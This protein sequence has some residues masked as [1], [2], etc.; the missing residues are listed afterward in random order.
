MQPTEILSDEHQ[1]ILTVIDA[2]E[3]ECKKLIS[4]EEIDEQFFKKAIDFI[5]HYADKF[6]HAKEEDIL[7]K[8][9]CNNAEKAHC[10]PVD[11]M[12]LE[13]DIGRKFVKGM[14]E[15]IRN[16]D[17]SQLIENAEG[18]ASLLQDHITKEDRILYPMCDEV[19]SSKSQEKMLK[20]FKEV[21]TNNIE[22][23]KKY[24]AITK[25]FE[26]RK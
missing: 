17:K 3:R 5:R 22:A 15:A 6:H 12:L 9:F 11:Q 14:K 1:N 8:E 10:N 13:H 21:E 26:E 18:Y 16:K 20:Q 7:F 2:I 23:K 4:G 24:L 19:I 25:E